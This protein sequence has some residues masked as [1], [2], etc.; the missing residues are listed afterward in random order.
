MTR[1]PAGGSIFFSALLTTLILVSP[2]ETAWAATDAMDPATSQ[3]AQRATLLLEQATEGRDPAAAARAHY[4]LGR[5][6]NS[7]GLFSQAEA[8]ARMAAD[9]VDRDSDPE[10]GLDI[11]LMLAAVIMRM[12]RGHEAAEIVLGSLD[13]ID[14]LG[15]IG[16]GV[17]ARITLSTLQSQAGA[18][19]AAR[20][21]ALAALE[22]A[23]AHNMTDWMARLLINLM[24][25]ELTMP[26]KQDR[27]GEPWMS[28][29]LELDPRELADETQISLLL[30]QLF[31]A[32][33]SGQLDDAVSLSELLARQ[34]EERGN[35][36]LSGMA[37]RETAQLFC[38]QGATDRARSHFE[39]SVTKLEQTDDAGEIGFTLNRW[40]EC[41]AAAG[42]FER[43]LELKRRGTELLTEGRQRRQD[44]LLLSA[45]LA[46]NTEQNLRE[47]E[48][49]TSRETLLSASL[50]RERW[51]ASALLAFSGLLLALLAI[52]WLRL[53]RVR[54]RQQA[55][56]R[57]AQTRAD[58]LA[59]TSHEIRNPAQ[60]LS[61]L[62]ES[63]TVQSPPL[64]NDPGFK[65]AL[66]SSRLIEHLARDY[67]DLA[68]SE[69]DR[70]TVHAK[71]V[72]ATRSIVEG[73]THLSHGLFPQAH[74]HFHVIV[75]D[76]VP[77]KIRT[78]GDRLTQV[79]L[80]G[81]INAFRHGGSGPVTL[82]V[83]VD[84]ET[85]QLRF[86]IE[87]NGPGFSCHDQRLF[88]PYWQA[89]G[90]DS[91]G[92]GLGLA[93]S[94]AIVKRL[95]GSIEARNVQP[96][97]AML[98]IWLPMDSLPAADEAEDCPPPFQADR[99]F[100]HVRVVILDD[101]PLSLLGLSAMAEALG[102]RVETGDDDS[103]LETWLETFDPHLV[104]LD[105]QLGRLTGEDIA[106]RIRKLDAGAGRGHRRILIISGS[107]HPE[108]AGESAHDE[109]LLKPLSLR[110][111]GDHLALID[112]TSN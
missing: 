2:A 89:A 26:P 43:A 56:Q 47:L 64:T 58:L 31:Y 9:L 41:E 95:G 92:S 94:A 76:D 8:Q 35:V 59:R 36:F 80:N 72:C 79:L 102:C 46:F 68:M 62:L 1:L 44:A 73:V 61:G 52:G 66:G 14:R 110:V 71:N 20:A 48:R 50:A 4:Q 104:I 86:E 25:I 88:E 75:G 45:S 70:L 10:L 54:E 82:R 5:H 18:P 21:T 34:A 69:Q 107:T 84:D 93:V 17:R 40:S 28:R 77:Q 22:T 100:P 85:D 37:E 101:D 6:F 99:R 16:A 15:L 106:R 63:L 42:N 55:E 60:G 29:I 103:N 96:H 57:L 91:S 23:E 12:G 19:E 39:S 97:G 98:I 49:L 105:Q 112:S 7:M 90:S 13:E 53:R 81:V 24:R 65:A 67:L 33:T 51:R 87:D 109:W 83:C 27:L 74:D 108:Q 3:F 11:D 30:A 32:R 111:L 38:D 78:D